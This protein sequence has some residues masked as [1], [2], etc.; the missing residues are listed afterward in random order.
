VLY[1]KF[2]INI[3]QSWFVTLQTG[4]IWLWAKVYHFGIQIL[5]IGDD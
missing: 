5:K 1:P 2:H 4:R 3:T